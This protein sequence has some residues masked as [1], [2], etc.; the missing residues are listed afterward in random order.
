MVFVRAAVD[1]DKDAVARVHVRSWQ[2]GYRGLIPDEHLGQMRAEDRA[3]RYHFG[4]DETSPH[5]VV[6]TDNEQIIGFVTCGASRDGD[7]PHVGEV[8]AL[9]VD[10]DHWGRGVGGVLLS[11]A[12]TYLRERS[13]DGGQLWVLEGNDRAVRFYEMDGWSTDGL[14]REAVVWG[15][16]INEIQFS[17]RL[18]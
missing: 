4:G 18:T 10:P 1:A 6:A 7:S 11:S 15:I 2:V 5:T 16:R 3:Q 13:C 9:Y 14:R 17:C 12:R 8:Y